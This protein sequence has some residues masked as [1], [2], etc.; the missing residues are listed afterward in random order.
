MR[1]VR[2]AVNNA[3]GSIDPRAIA[4]NSMRRVM[5]GADATAAQQ[6]GGIGRSAASLSLQ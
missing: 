6:A 3:T 2:P 5:S 1:C 4:L